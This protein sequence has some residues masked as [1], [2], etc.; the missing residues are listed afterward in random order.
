MA[1]SDAATQPSP[2]RIDAEGVFRDLGGGEREQVLWK[3]LVRV[4]I[5]TTADGPFSEDFF[6]VLAAANGTGCVV[7]GGYAGELLSRL[8]R[9]PR[10]DNA[11]VIRASQC[12]SEAKFPCWSGE[13]GEGLAAG[14]AS[15]TA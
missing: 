6:W 14:G 3:D 4:W 8:Q 2:I 13:A 15:P 11:Q 7:A 5:Q 9:L 1:R 10:F 12:T